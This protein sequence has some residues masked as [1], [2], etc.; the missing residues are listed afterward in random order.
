MR[1]DDIVRYDKSADGIVITFRDG[2]T[3][4]FPANALYA[5]RLKHGQLLEMPIERAPP[6]TI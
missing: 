5:I 2:Y 6:E 1:P 4:L 3:F